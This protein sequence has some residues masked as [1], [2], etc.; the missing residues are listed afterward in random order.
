MKKILLRILTN[1]LLPAFI[2]GC[3]GYFG[4][5][6][7]MWKHGNSD[8]DVLEL[9]KAAGE[10]FAICF[11]VLCFFMLDMRRR[12]QKT[13]AQIDVWEEKVAKSYDIEE[14]EKYIILLKN[15]RGSMACFAL[16]H[17]Q[18]ANKVIMM[19]HAKI[20]TIKQLTHK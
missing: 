19:A 13:Y 1:F 18:E 10:S 14:L 4:I 15:Y 7:L 12:S 2:A 5:F 9:S 20:D 11:G 6:L 8:R 3:F 16:Q 17:M